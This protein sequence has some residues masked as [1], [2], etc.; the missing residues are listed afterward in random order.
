[1]RNRALHDALRDFALEAAALLLEEQRAGAE[2]EF[3]VDE[4]PRRRGPVL[5]RYRPPPR[6]GPVLYRYRPLTERFIHERWD[7]L[8]ELP[9]CP[10][11]AETLG[12]G[13][14]VYLRVRGLR[15]EQA[16]PALTAVLERLYEDATSF[17]FPEERFE[18][19]YEEVERTL[20]QGT[21]HTVVLAPVPGLFLDARRVELGEALV[22]A[23]GDCVDAPPE[24][25]WPAGAEEPATLC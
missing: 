22:L 11:A 1:M 2:L 3:D 17:E 6:R 5:Y 24:V 4:E 25:A 9:C 18:R 7:R 21:V 23:R 16:E 12:S 20:Y 13:A 8:R 14:S 15:G 10:R 19:V